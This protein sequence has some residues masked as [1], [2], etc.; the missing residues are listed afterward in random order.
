VVESSTIIGYNKH[1]WKDQSRKKGG[2]FYNYTENALIKKLLEG[3]KDENILDRLDI[4]IITGYRGQKELIKKS[5]TNSGY[6][7]IAKMIDIN[8]LDA[9]QGR[10]NNII[11]GRRNRSKY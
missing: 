1:I 4:G 11:R 5:V 8:T 3:F 2:S 7:R 9:F 10:E 6:D